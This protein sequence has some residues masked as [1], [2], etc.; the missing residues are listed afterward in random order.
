LVMKP[1]RM[2]MTMNLIGNDNNSEDDENGR[3]DNNNELDEKRISMG[4]CG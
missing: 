3:D 1:I 4:C 2:T